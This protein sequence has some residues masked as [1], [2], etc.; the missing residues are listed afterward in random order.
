[1][2]QQQVRTRMHV[3]SSGVVIDA[4]MCYTKGHEYQG[5][6]KEQM[7]TCYV[8]GINPACLQKQLAAEMTYVEEGVGGL[9]GA[10]WAG[11]G[12]LQGDG[13]AAC[14]NQDAWNC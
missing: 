8:P 13:T 4:M 10:D 12:L 1:M 2:A 14:W 7:P 3:C 11:V 5:L 6:R 9:E